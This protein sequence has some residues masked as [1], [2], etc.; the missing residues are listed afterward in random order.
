M[1]EWEKVSLDDFRLQME[2][3]SIRESGDSIIFPVRVYHKNGE[4]A[5]LKPVPVRADFYRD[6]KKT[7]D[8]QK[9][10]V[11]I[12]MQRVKDDIMARSKNGVISIEDK[13]AWMSK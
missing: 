6:L 3:E 13:I 2:V 7:P 10:L 9:A 12:F 4:F 11:K 5:F 1:I 8:W